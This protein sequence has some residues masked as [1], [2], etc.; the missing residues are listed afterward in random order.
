MFHRMVVILESGAESEN[1]MLLDGLI[2]GPYVASSSAEM[3]P[4]DSKLNFTFMT[5]LG[6]D[7]TF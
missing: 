7:T 1:A 2:D 4:S 6:T 3:Y 5:N